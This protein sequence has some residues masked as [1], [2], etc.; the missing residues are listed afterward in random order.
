MTHGG[1]IYRIAGQLGIAENL[2]MDFSASINPLGIPETVQTEIKKIAGF[3]NHIVSISNYPDPDTRRLREK[4]SGCYGIDPERVLCGNGSTELIYL[5][6]RALRPGRVLIPGP[7]FSEYERAVRTTCDRAGIR[8][9]VLKKEDGFRL[10]P[11]EFISAMKGIDMAFLC[12]PNNPTGDVIKKDSVLEMAR[13]AKKHKCILVVDEAFMDFCPEESVINEVS[14]YLVVLRSMTKF[15]ALSGLR[16][17]YG[18]LP[19]RLVRRLKAYKEPWTLNSLAES[20]AVAA[21]DDGDYGKRT[22]RLIA[23]EK[24]FLENGFEKA[25]ISYYPSAANFYLLKVK[26]AGKTAAALLKKRIAVREC[27][28]FRGL[29][30]S[31]IRVAVKARKENTM[32][33]RELLGDETDNRKRG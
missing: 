1:N 7:T 29:G 32:L 27:S 33:I 22:F 9:F 17:G 24:R 26:D 23:R 10:K 18:V 3:K 6:P 4:I 5:L 16:V 21:L 19:V 11:D 14:P 2:V 8:Y 25:E 15:Y 20:A 13:A 31:H 12:N 30:N 28:D